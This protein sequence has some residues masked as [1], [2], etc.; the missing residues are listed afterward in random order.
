MNRRLLYDI[1]LGLKHLMTFKVMV[2]NILRHLKKIFLEELITRLGKNEDHFSNIIVMV[3]VS[4]F[5]R[6]FP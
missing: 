5:F 6:I 4:K 1:S 3:I 2:L